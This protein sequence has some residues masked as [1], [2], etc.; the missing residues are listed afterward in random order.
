MHEENVTL[1][2]DL[3]TD[4]TNTSLNLISTSRPDSTKAMSFQS[5]WWSEK[6]N[7]IYCFGGERRPFGPT[8]PESIWGFKPDGQGGGGW[9]EQVGPNTAI[10]FPP[11]IIRPADG[12]SAFDDD[13]AYYV[14]GFASQGTTNAVNLGWGITRP[15][16][17]LLTFDFSSQ[18]L[19]NSSNDGGY[20]SSLYREDQSLRSGSLL[21]VPPFG[22]KGILLAIGGGDVIGRQSDFNNVTVFDKDGQNWYSQTASGD[23]PD[24]KML[25][26]AV[27]AQGG[28]N[29]TYEVYASV[30]QA[31]FN[32]T[33]AG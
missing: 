23:I 12:A 13:G 28:D 16:P 7:M 24:P 5:L 6:N 8:L 27:G 21:N 4:W 33:L 3:S 22:N 1:S 30:F 15:V 19:T 29:S 26:C 10:P 25:F 2:L 18:T 32:F 11:Q 20:F 9:T 31:N 14:G 17:G